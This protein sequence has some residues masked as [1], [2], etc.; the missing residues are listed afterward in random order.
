MATQTRVKIGKFDASK[1]QG[2]DRDTL[3]RLYRTMFLSRRLDDREIQLKRQNK[4]YFQISGAGHEAVLAA[5][6]LAPEARLRLVSSLLSRSRADACARHYALRNAPPGRRRQGRSSLRRPPDAFA[7]G[8]PETQRRL[9]LFSHRHAIPPSRRHRGSGSYYDQFPKALEQARKAPLGSAVNLSSRRNRLRLRRRRHDQR[10][11][12]FRIAEYRVQQAI[13]AFSILIEDNGYA[14]SVPVEVQTAGG[15]ISKLVANYPGLLVEECDGTDPLESYAALSRAVGLLPR[16]QRP[17]VD[18]RAR[19]PSL[20]PFAFRRRETLQNR[21]R[22]RRRKRTRSHPEIRLVPRARRHPRTQEME[23]LE[24]EVE[25]EVTEAA[26]RALHAELPAP[27]SIYGLVYSPD[28]DPA[29]R[30]FESAPDSR[31]R[32]Q[33]DG[34]NGLRHSDG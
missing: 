22:A 12:I 2:L 20:F 21:R 9:A 15:S 23:A 25:R 29:G 8:K 17:R 3:I 24:A 4:I 18:P 28:V 30:E 27:D 33:N 32:A 34:R 19:Y 7:L 5:A 31:R 6:G 10:R 16:A 11:R 26:D 1:Y 13:A 14:I